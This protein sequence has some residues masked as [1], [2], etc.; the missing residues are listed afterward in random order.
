MSRKRKC[1]HGSI[2]FRFELPLTSEGV[3]F[4]NLTID[5]YGCQNEEGKPEADIDSVEF[6]GVEVKPLLEIVG[7]MREID[8]AAADHVRGL[9]EVS[10]IHEAELA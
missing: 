8:A 7:G 10:Q 5:G 2:Y 6:Q 3:F 9:F 1:N 4:D